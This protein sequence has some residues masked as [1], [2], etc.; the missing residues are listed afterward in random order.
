MFATAYWI[1]VNS[2]NKVSFF[3]CCSCSLWFKYGALKGDMTLMAVNSAGGIL[4]LAFIII[5]YANT[6]QRVSVVFSLLGRQG[7]SL[8]ATWLEQASLS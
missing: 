4:N 3:V 7:K 1:L 6:I 2:F 8:M 5:Y